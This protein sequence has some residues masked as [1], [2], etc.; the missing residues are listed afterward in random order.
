M[1]TDFTL[2]CLGQETLKIATLLTGGALDLLAVKIFLVVD[3]SSGTSK[4]PPALRL[5]GRVDIRVAGAT[6]RFTY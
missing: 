1:G 2:R 3:S 5:G 4:A 6:C